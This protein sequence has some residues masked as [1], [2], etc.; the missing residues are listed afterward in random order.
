MY[1]PDPTPATRTRIRDGKAVH[2]PVPS[3]L[4]REDIRTLRNEVLE[5]WAFCGIR[6]GM[7]LLDVPLAFMDYAA[8]VL[9]VNYDLSDDELEFLLTN[10]KAWHASMMQHI[11][12]GEDFVSRLAA[13]RDALRPPEPSATPAPPPAPAVRL[14]WWKRLARFN[15]QG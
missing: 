6:G 15:R 5:R 9:R 10:S 2:E 4:D 13:S 12:G 1:L 14:P 11:T 3:V 7:A 8:A